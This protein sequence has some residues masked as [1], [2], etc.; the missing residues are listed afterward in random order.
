MKPTKDSPKTTRTRP[1]ARTPESRENQMI[2]LAMDLVEQ[3]LTAGTASSQETTHFLKLGSIK[4]R[5]ELLLLE[6]EIELKRAK[7]ESIQ[8][9]KRVEELYV[10]ALNAM[11]SYSG[12]SDADDN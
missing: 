2:S 12:K 9:A 3:R 1:P 11:K 10:N 7:T 8:S 4:Q 5:K 6:Q